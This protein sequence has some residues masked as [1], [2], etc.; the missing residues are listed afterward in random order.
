MAHSRTAKKRIRQNETRRAQNRIR[1][2]RTKT[3]TKRVLTAVE[4]ANLEQADAQADESRIDLENKEAGVT[5]LRLE[6]AAAR[7]ILEEGKTRAYEVDGEIQIIESEIKHL[8]ETMER[9]QLLTRQSMSQ[10][11]QCRSRSRE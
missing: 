3:Q 10:K 1:R 4:D 2:S 6:E 5:S 9:Q 8:T 11:S 7:N